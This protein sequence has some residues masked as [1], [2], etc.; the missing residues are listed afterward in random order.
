MKNSSKNNSRLNPVLDS[1][2]EAIL[3]SV[4]G[5]IIHV[6][7]ETDNFSDLV[8]TPNVVN[9][10]AD[11]VFSSM[12]KNHGKYFLK[13]KEDNFSSLIDNIIFNTEKVIKVA[14]TKKQIL[15]AS[16]II[17]ED[18]YETISL[19]VVKASVSG[20][21]TSEDTK[22]LDFF[23]SKFK[24]DVSD[25]VYAGSGINLSKLPARK[26]LLYLD[27]ILVA[28]GTNKNKD[29][30]PAEELQA[31]YL[32][33]IGMPLVEE[34]ITDAI[35]GVFY[36]S[37]LVRIKSGKTPGSVK[38]VKKGG[39][40][41]VRAKAYVYKNRFPREAYQLKDKQEQGLLRYSV[42]LGFGQS[43]CSA[44]HKT[45]DPGKPFCDHLML[46]HTPGDHNFSRIVRD[47][48][49][50]GGAY[51]QNPAEKDAISLE[52]VDPADDKSKNK[53]ISSSCVNNIDDTGK[54]IV[55]DSSS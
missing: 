8:S 17:T 26:D 13:K 48:Y 21:L 10:I 22:D 54:D 43:E 15:K 7:S 2:K 49:F 32:T 36:E 37:S 1:D 41:A 18:G 5:S 35:R 33:L 28:E 16:E 40:L 55:N 4:R 25:R 12:Y 42:E 6:L 27:L 46:R 31:R 38:I 52:V 50:I 14:E 24:N 11:A 29:T 39:K 53:K 51:T 3:D 20:K 9:S 19:N 23:E 30:I 45:F 47:I 44:C 34:H